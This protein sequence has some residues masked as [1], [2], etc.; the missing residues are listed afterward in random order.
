MPLYL[1]NVGIAALAIAA[2]GLA[3]GGLVPEHRLRLR[4]ALLC[5][6]VALMLVSPLALAVSGL[7]DVGAVPVGFEMPTRPLL[8]QTAAMVA[9]ADVTNG[10]S[11][12]DAASIPSADRHT[13]AASN[14]R[15]S[16][17]LRI[18]LLLATL[19]WLAGAI[20]VLARWTRG[21]LLIRRLRRSLAPSCSPRLIALVAQASRKAGLA[22]DLPVYTSVLAPGPLVLGTWN[23]AIVLPLGIDA[24]LSDEELLG[25][26]AHEAAHVARRDPLVAVVERLAAALYWWN[27]LLHAINRRIHFARECICD[28]YA[29]AGGGDGDQLALALVK[30]GE[31][32]L[33]PRTP[34]AHAAMLFDELNLTARIT[35]LTNK[36][37]SMNS[38]FNP[39]GLAAVLTLTILAPAFVLVPV[40][41][42]QT[43]PF[44]AKQSTTAAGTQKPTLPARLSY[45]DG[46]AEGKRSLGGSGDLISF[47]LP[48]ESAKVAGIRIHGARYGLPQ[49]PKEDFVIYFL[50]GDMSETVATK[51]A[52][53]SRFKRGEPGWVEIKFPKPIEVPKE[54]WVCLDFRAHQTKGV[55]V[56]VDNSTDGSHSRIGLPGME[57]REANVGGDWMVEALLDAKAAGTTQKAE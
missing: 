2:V 34:L 12:N 50:N 29:L 40:L 8:P 56:S 53:Y 36:E 15:S 27:P 25:I 42:A 7:L 20:V 21:I 35:R 47:T 11:G 22:R 37:R 1:L 54:F 6:A 28:E 52:P 26:L 33:G 51:T 43:Y 30:A 57:S 49:P 31:W 14:P 23:A 10:P 16:D 4:Y 45:N 5:A 48:D 9:P 3:A 13:S 32:S 19:A 41:K 44:R 55:Y 24:T 39:A 17:P 18:G 46:T 38:R